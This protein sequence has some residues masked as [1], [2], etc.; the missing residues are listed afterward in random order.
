M[1]DVITCTQ[2]DDNG[3][4]LKVLWRRRCQLSLAIIHCE[5][6]REM[7]ALQKGSSVHRRLSL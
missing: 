5:Q 3:L 2:F 6:R 4:W 7:A 1:H